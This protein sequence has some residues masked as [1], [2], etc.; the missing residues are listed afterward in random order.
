MNDLNTIS[1]SDFVRNAQIKFLQGS[2]SVA[3]NMKESGLFR[4]EDVPQNTGNV[5]EYT[6]ID[7][8]QYAS[9][10][11]EG[12]Q[13]ARAKVQQGY[14]KIAR[15]YRVSKEIGITYEMRTQNKY[16]DVVAKLTNLGA[17]AQNRMELDMSHRITFGTATT[18][19]NSDGNVIDISMGDT[20]AL[21]ST[22]HTVRGASTTYRNRLANNPQVSR[23]SVEAMEKLVV[24][25]T[26]NQ[27]GQKKAVPFDV[28]WTTDD[29]NTVNTTR[30]I[31]KA[32]SGVLAPNA[33]VPN[34]YQS[35]YRHVILPLI[36]TDANG[37]V[38]STK[39]KYWGLASTM[40][41]Q[42]FLGIHEAPHLQTPVVGNNGE[43]FSTQDWKFA[44]S[45]GFFV[46][47]VSGIWI[48]GSTG[49]GT[50]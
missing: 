12:E 10:K 22:A 21:F 24:E 47:I 37:N 38:D 18:Y 42:A 50:A 26:I 13:H 32:T 41:S 39:A 46:T 11:P 30:E 3:M 29:P 45:A 1:L 27:F 28:L 2:D 43:D 20:L 7:L 23:G 17:L 14:S 8:E 49:D 36:A 40:M 31:L 19:T 16:T 48:K 25:E 15:L 35:K 4:V 5:R 44:V 33:G 34:V 6:E 9:I